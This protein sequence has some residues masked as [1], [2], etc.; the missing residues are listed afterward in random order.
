MSIILLAAVAASLALHPQKASSTGFLSSA[1]LR[2]LRSSNSRALR[3]RL[4][5]PLCMQAVVTETSTE[6]KQEIS[7]ERRA[8]KG[9]WPTPKNDRIMRA[10]RGEEVDEVPVWMMRQAGRYL[11]EYR[12]L[13]AEHNFLKVCQDPEL[14][15][16]V[17]LQPYRRYPL[18]AVIIF[19]DI[20]VIPVAMGQPLQMIKGRGPVFDYGF[21]K[22]ADLEKLNFN[23]DVEETLGYVADAIYTTKKKLDN[24][25][26][27]FGFCGAPWT[28][29]AYMV[30][31]ES[32]KDWQ[33]AKRWL[34]DHPE[35]SHKLLE[36][37]AR[38]SAQ[39]LIMQYDAGAQLLQV[40]DTNA[41][42]L[43]PH[44]YEEFGAKYMRMIADEVK[45]A[46]SNAI[47]IAFPKEMP[48]A[49]FADSS[50]DAISLGWSADP[51][52]MRQRFGDK[53]TLQGNLDPHAMY[54]D[55]EIIRKHTIA[56]VKKFGK[57][58]YIANLGHGMQ[59]GMTP[60]AAGAFVSAVKEASR[61]L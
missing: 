2:R 40:F 49:S 47:L 57:K 17:T 18:D 46:R 35:A 51:H 14:A 42:V 25:I 36:G 27:V 9:E 52:E 13:V 38:I 8:N 61:D 37:I 20:L 45:K 44:M 6:R 29:M 59:P 39:Y 60:E 58:R 11:P 16:E 5:R 26:P 15:A 53:L 12:E 32:S 24:E 55:P 56:M 30:Q 21:E 28:I 41:G 3:S 10:A 50:Y 34:Y 31:G 33:G 54:S 1:P 19:S 23:P 7:A 22:P 48:L 4:A 43:S